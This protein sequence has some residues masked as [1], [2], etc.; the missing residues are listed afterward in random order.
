VAGLKLEEVRTRLAS[1]SP[2]KVADGGRAYKAAAAILTTARQEIVDA[3]DHLSERWRGPAADEALGALRQLRDSASELAAKSG[4]TGEAL[5]RYGGTI[6]PW[7]R[8][9]LPGDGFIRSGRD[10]E[11]AQKLMGRLNARIEQ[12]YLAVPGEIRMQLPGIGQ[13]GESA[14]TDPPSSYGSR[15]VGSPQGRPG[16]IPHAFPA[17]SA[18]PTSEITSGGGPGSHQEGPVWP[19]Q[20]GSQGGPATELA[21]LHPASP[22][23]GSGLGPTATGSPAGPAGTGTSGFAPVLPGTSSRTG[24]PTAGSRGLAQGGPSATGRNSPFGPIGTTPSGPSILGGT[25]SAAARPEAEDR[26]RSTWLAEDRDIW[27]PDSPEPVPPV[28]GEP[29]SPDRLTEWQARSK[30]VTHPA[31][32]GAENLREDR[33]AEQQDELD[34]MLDELEAELDLEIVDLVEGR[35]ADGA[36]A[37]ALDENLD[38]LLDDEDGR[39]DHSRP[40]S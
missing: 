21:S 2:E 11:Y 22:N 31:E 40:A 12:T 26:E 18:A 34:L 24:A 39:G 19:S 9:H 20:S 5:H 4:Q 33:H 8:N 13:G 25:G 16:G 29:V 1:T 36:E 23:S 17:A 27:G 7:Y 14:R 35:S 38:D 30:T 6:L 3:I 37:S 15:H 10:D 32:T 28:I